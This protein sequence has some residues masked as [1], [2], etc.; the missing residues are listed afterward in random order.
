VCTDCVLH[1]SWW[2]C[3]SCTGGLCVYWLRIAHILMLE[4]CVYWLRIAHIMMLELCVYWLRIAHIMMVVLFLHWQIVCVLTAYCTRHDVRIVCVLTAYCT[5]HD[6][7]AVLALADCVCTDCVL[8]TSWWLCCSC[9]GGL[10][11]YWLRIA[12]IMM[13]EHLRRHCQRFIWPYGYA[14]A[15]FSVTH[16]Y[17]NPTL[18]LSKFGQKCSAYTWVY[19]VYSL[20][21]SLTDCW[22][23]SA[24]TLMF[25][26]SI[27]LPFVIASC[28]VWLYKSKCKQWYW[29]L[30]GIGLKRVM[31]NNNSR[32]CSAPPT[33]SPQ[34]HY[35]VS[36]RCKKEKTSDAAWMLLSSECEWR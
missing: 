28:I 19:M 36:M 8:H 16:V 23:G 21:S 25:I 10:C 2:L 18:L 3:C 9:T 35:I 15:S 14:Y 31:S 26:A 24:L 29:L 27:R 1:T 22:V 5:H 17:A 32:I 7:C 6:G 13:L 20:L 11:V 30:S 4:L 12:H 33:I 34:V